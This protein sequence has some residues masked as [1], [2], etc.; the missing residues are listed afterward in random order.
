MDDEFEKIIDEALT[1]VGALG[2]QEKGQNLG[3]P[4]S[5]GKPGDLDGGEAAKKGETALPASKKSKSTKGAHQG[6]ADSPNG[7]TEF[8]K[9]SP[10]DMMFG[11]QK[12]HKHSKQA[13]PGL[14]N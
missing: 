5:I 2:T 13:R 9:M 11:T 14:D 7:P 4:G 12:E 1:K 10:V 8:H 6:P 3:K